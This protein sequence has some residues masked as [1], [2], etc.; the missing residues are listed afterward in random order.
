MPTRSADLTREWEPLTCAHEQALS[1]FRESYDELLAGESPDPLAIVGAYRSGKTQLMYQMFREAWD[2]DIGAIYV[3]DPGDLLNE[4]ENATETDITEWLSNRIEE[5]VAAYVTQD[6]ENVTWFPNASSEQKAEWLDTYVTVDSA[7]DIDKYAIFIDEVEQHY[8]EFLEA[9][10][11]DDSNPLRVINDEVADT[12]K[13]WSFGMLSAYEFIGEADWGRLHEIRVPPLDVGEVQNRLEEERPDLTSLANVVWWMGRGRTGLIIKFIEELPTDAAADI[14]DWVQSMADVEAQ[15]TRVID[16]IWTDLPSEKWD[17]A[18][19]ALSFQADG[20]DSWLLTDDEVY[21]IE[22]MVDLVSN[23]LFDATEFPS[24]DEG[25]TAKRIIRRNTER[26]FDGLCLPDQRLFPHREIIFDNTEIE[27]LLSLIEDQILSFEPTGPSRRRAAEAL[28]IDPAEF[29]SGFYEANPETEVVNT[30]VTVPKPSKIDSAFQPI[31]LNPDLVCSTPTRELRE[32][33]DEALAINTSHPLDVS[34]FFCPTETALERQLQTVRSDRDITEPAIFVVPTDLEEELPAEYDIFERHSLI[35]VTTHESSLMWD[36]IVNLWGTLEERNMMTAGGV[37]DSVRRELLEDIDS[38][39]VR[40]TIETLYDQVERFSQEQ[41][42]SFADDYIKRYSRPDTTTL[43][44]EENRLQGETPFWTSGEFGE[45][46]VTLSYLLLLSETPDFGQR[47]GN[48]HSAIETA[49]D[50]D[51]ISGGRSFPYGEFLENLY[52]AN[53]FT[54][55]LNEEREH[56]SDGEHFDDS[57]EHTQIAL[58]DLAKDFDEEDVIAR[59]NDLD[60]EARNGD[61]PLLDVDVSRHAY[62]FLR[63]N[64]MCKIAT[65]DSSDLD[66]AARLEDLADDLRSTKS[67]VEGALE[68]IE[69]ANETLTE[70]ECAPVGTWV[71][72]DPGIYETYHNNLETII[73]GVENLANQIEFNPGISPLAYAYWMQLRQFNTQMSGKFDERETTLAEMDVTTIED[74]KQIYNDLYQTAENSDVLIEYFE[75]RE[76]LRSQVEAIGD[77]VFDYAAGEHRLTLPANIERVNELNENARERRQDLERI[78]ALFDKL[79]NR[80]EGVEEEVESIEEGLEELLSTAL[81]APVG[82]I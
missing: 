44:W 56:Y 36:F 28:D 1:N 72:L 2:R 21:A 58:Y 76:Q 51:L 26:V 5:E 49:L 59:L 18:C 38:R 6:P 15:S 13:V 14:A 43:L 70:P 19:H 57:V 50:E 42:D 35:E 53:G 8:E 62:A 31:A 67:D 68:R 52:G 45:I 54:P 32:E 3:S 30:E 4:F 39:D 11:T 46:P 37:D 61:I 81:E 65:S 16:P 41:V 24:D 47:Y 34:I 12:L 64:L 74:L 69:A 73:E 55:R 27:G 10:E 17:P 82:E 29:S 25:Q 40:N 7:A 80:H 71:N 33:M 9:I 78:R 77:D 60:N 63:A 66:L 48:I 23:I 20:L 75:S 22:D 79:E